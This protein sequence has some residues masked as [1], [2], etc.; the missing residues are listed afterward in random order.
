M[1]KLSPE[2]EAIWRRITRTVRPLSKAPPKPAPAAATATTKPA[3]PRPPRPPRPPTASAP[4][5]TPAKPASAADKR[6]KP[7]IDAG[8]ERAIRRGRI[9]VG[10][11]LDMHGMTQ[12]QARAALSRFLNRAQERGVKTTLVI[13]GKGAAVSPSGA[14]SSGTAPGRGVLRARLVEWLRSRALRD[15]VWG[16]A[17]AH[18]KHGGAG[19]FYVFLRSAARR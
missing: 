5:A 19:A 17:E 2:D 12:D 6:P 7:A 11:R 4:A 10:A 3:P 14:A 13:T 1:E 8:H 9:G 18:R 15:L 16:Y